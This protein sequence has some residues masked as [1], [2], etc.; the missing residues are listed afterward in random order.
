M[1]LSLEDCVNLVNAANFLDISE[2]VSLA[3]AR[4]AYEMINCDVEEAR[5]KFG[6]FPDMTEEEMKEMDK[7]PLD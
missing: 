5:Q 6:I 3:S 1:P 4:L 2:L 7:Y